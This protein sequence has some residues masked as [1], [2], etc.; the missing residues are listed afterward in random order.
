LRLSSSPRIHLSDNGLT[1]PRWK[2]GL[3]V[4]PREVTFMMHNPRPMSMRKTVQLMVILTLLAWATQTLFKQWGYGG[5]ILPQAM[6][7]YVPADGHGNAAVLELRGRVDATGDVVTLRDVCRWSDQDGATLDSLGDL[8]LARFGREGVTAT[9]VRKVTVNDIR[10]AL[11]DAGASL[12]NIE[13][14]GAAACAVV[15]GDVNEETVRQLMNAEPAPSPTD[16]TAADTAAASPATQP[17]PPQTA[18]AE[19]V[20]VA[21]VP[22][23]PL[24]DLLVNDLLER[25]ALAKENA[26]ITFDP[27]DEATLNLTSPKQT[28]QIDSARAG[29]LGPIAWDVV[30]KSDQ[31]ERK[32]TVTAKLAAYENQVVL[33]R[34]L[35]RGQSILKSDVVARRVL[36]EKLAEDKLEKPEQAIGAIATRALKSGELLTND[37]VTEPPAVQAGDFVTVSMK[38]GETDVETVARALDA[39]PRGGTIRAKNEA[40]G[41]VY[42]V[43]V[44]GRGAG[45][46]KA[47]GEGDVASTN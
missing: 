37:A 34:P 9:G 16:A 35:S 8:V 31:G 15:R 43:Q 39:G 30:I 2:R 19:P 14:S 22:Q 28:F 11:H 13:I 46:V 10:A 40:T 4:L 23:T 38:I 17:A 36:V 21:D 12:T 18:A 24:K 5:I 44:T 7:Q 26:Q 1:G 42:Q 33:A 41:Q 47:V 6:A 45:D 20:A 27:A 3:T 25:L 32:V 29:Q